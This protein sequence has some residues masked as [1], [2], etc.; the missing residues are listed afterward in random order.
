MEPCQR[1]GID[2][3]KMT[4]ETQVVMYGASEHP[5][6]DHYDRIVTVVYKRNEK[7]SEQSVSLPKR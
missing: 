1:F 7:L 2:K 6:L 4:H 5:D 3:I